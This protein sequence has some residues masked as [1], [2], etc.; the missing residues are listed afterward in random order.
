VNRREF[1]AVAAA[2]VGGLRAQSAADRNGAA[3]D[4][5]YQALEELSSH[6]TPQEVTRAIR[7]LRAALDE[8]PS[9][10][11]AHYYRYLCLKRL[12]PKSSSLKSDIDAAQ[13]YNSE[14]LRDRRD[15]FVLA[16][17]RIY[18]NLVTIG[19]KWALVVGISRF[20][21]KIGAS[22]LN[23]AASDASAFASL[24]KDP[25]VGRFPSEQVFL[26][27]DKEA[28][29]GN[30]R[31][32]L[33]TIA[34]KAKPED[35]VVVYIA[36]H[37]SARDD[38]IRK[39]SYLLT[40]DTNV[41]SRDDIFGTGLGMVDVSGIIS[42]RCVAQR[43]LAIMDTCHSGAGVAVSTD[44]INRLRDG[45]G[46]YVISSCG[47]QESAYEDAGRGFF[48]ASLIDRLSARNG[49]I[50]IGDLFAQVQAEVSDT[51]QRKKN[52]PQHPVMMKS[53]S[54]A[55]IVLGAAVGG[56]SDG[57]LTA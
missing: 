29:T 9:F 20:Q 19:Q 48:T 49:C 41:T 10:G 35:V 56:A 3:R 17:P 6:A 54:A 57:C 22:P 25:G 32:R 53:D 21:P 52:A 11:D 15:P 47:E 34:T 1:I 16:V 31:A 46:R 37:G 45:A 43:T 44:E 13:L 2:S 7:F 28:T 42:S 40:Y 8:Y 23:F 39:V 18:D 51:V 27:T 24:L 26:L 12:N 33:N 30:I 14:A 50:R 55:E 5:V 36:T 4:L 38:D